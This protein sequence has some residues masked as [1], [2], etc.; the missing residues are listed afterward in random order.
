MIDETDTPD[1]QEDSA[2]LLPAAVLRQDSRLA[3]QGWVRRFLADKHRTEE[4]IQLYEQMG[5]EVLA[6]PIVEGDLPDACEDCQL[7]VLLEFRV[8][9]TRTKD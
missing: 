5:L 7:A 3:N 1:M 8:I 2:S 4:A 9:Y 6:E